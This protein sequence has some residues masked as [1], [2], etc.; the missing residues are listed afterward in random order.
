MELIVNSQDIRIHSSFGELE[1]T[2]INNS[3]INKWLGEAVFC[4]NDLTPRNLILQSRVSSCGKFK[5]K[6]A[7]INDWEI[8]GFY[9][10]SYELSLQ[11]TYLG[12]STCMY[13]STCF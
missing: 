12:A 11:D 10:A 6:L 13:H 8:A 7:S 9:P 3:D 2:V 5:Y 4:H 1:S